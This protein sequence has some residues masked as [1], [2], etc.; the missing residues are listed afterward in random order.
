MKEVRL[1]H[2]RSISQTTKRYLLEPHAFT[3]YHEYGCNL[4]THLLIY[5]NSSVNGIRI[6]PVKEL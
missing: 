5:F 2:L 4:F 6:Q 3:D 1:F